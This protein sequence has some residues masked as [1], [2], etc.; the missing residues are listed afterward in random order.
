MKPYSFVLADGTAPFHI[1]GKVR[2]TILFAGAQIL[3]DAYI[4][5]QLCTNIILGMDYI[6]L[7]NLT[8]NVKHQIISIEHQ[9]RI[10]TMNINP[11]QSVT[12]IS[13]I[14]SKAVVIPPHSTRE[15][16]VNVPI[17]SIA[18]SLVPNRT[19]SNASS[20]FIRQTFIKFNN[21]RSTL[22]FSNTSSFPRFINKGY[23]VGFLLYHLKL[24]SLT[25]TPTLNKSS[26]STGFAGES[27]AFDAFNSHWYNA[28]P[29]RH[30]SILV[31]PFYTRYFFSNRKP[32]CNS[33]LKCNRALNDPFTELTN[34]IK[35]E[36][37]REDLHSLLIRFFKL[38][39]T[40]KHNIANTSIHHVINTIPHS[41]PACKPYPQP[42]KEQAMYKLIQEFLRAGLIS[43]SHSPYAA[44]AILVKKKD[45]SLRFVV[46]YKKTKFNHY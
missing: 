5:R 32:H 45:G 24:H 22:F 8:F 40:S 29:T 30:S 43:E 10:L 23:H 34:S 15:V 38:F 4:A 14:S 39:D 19:L 18:S 33:I 21:Y 31:E 6:N 35:N 26:G 12:R 41:P 42:D 44:P 13:V 11:D 27:T 3:I 17:S 9:D 25:I 28:A 16:P 37:H 7:Y 46:D 2:I 36:K 1:V 20:L